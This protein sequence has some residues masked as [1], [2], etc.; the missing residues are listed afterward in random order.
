MSGSGISRA[1]CKSAPRSTQITTPATHHSVLLQAGC[2]SCSPTNSVKALKARA[3]KQVCVWLWVKQCIIP[4]HDVGAGSLHSSKYS[5]QREF[6]TGA[7]QL[8]TSGCS[9]Q[10]KLVHLHAQH[11]TYVKRFR[12]HVSVRVAEKYQRVKEVLPSEARRADRGIG[13]WGGAA[14]V[15]PT[16]PLILRYAIEGKHLQKSQ[17]LRFY[18]LAAL[19]KYVYYYYYF[20]YLLLLINK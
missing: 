14:V 16:L 10:A 6:L 19:H 11:T 3:V 1:T 12:Q 5:K 15:C 7:S 8:K 9:V 2:P 20:I 13:S 4:R 17:H 18:Y